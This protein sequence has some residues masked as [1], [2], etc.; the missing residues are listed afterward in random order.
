MQAWNHRIDR[1]NGQV[2]N[3]SYHAFMLNPTTTTAK[4]HSQTELTL[5]ISFTGKGYFNPEHPNLSPIGFFNQ[6][7]YRIL[8]F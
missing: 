5:R 1:S 3:L 6:C 7:H 4:F 2:T 8:T